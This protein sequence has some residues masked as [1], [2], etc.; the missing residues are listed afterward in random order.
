MNISIIKC[1]RK[2]VC[3][4][5]NPDLTVT[6]R[7]PYRATKREIA[8]ILKEKEPWIFK[9]IELM[10]EKQAEYEAN[11]LPA[12]SEIELKQLRERAHTVIPERVAFF[13][14]QMG[15]TYGRISI[16]KQKTRWGSCSS[17]GNLNFNC[18][19]LLTP[20]EVLDY[21]VVHELCH[22]IEMNH[23]KAFWKEVENVLP[24]YRI[25]KDWLKKEG[26]MVMRRGKCTY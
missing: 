4:R 10:K 13:A 2:T 5:V 23:S 19:L 18:L 9:Q 12:L 1:R 17:K 21:V 16:R 25:A 14:D 15:I 22:R 6:V 3:I 11:Q 20:P 26:A 8:R 24:D 7:A